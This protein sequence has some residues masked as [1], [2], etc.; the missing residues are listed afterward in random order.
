MAH[1][2][3]TDNNIILIAGVFDVLS[4]K[5][6][7]RA[8]FHA[9]VVTGF[10]VSA[11]YLGEPDFGLLTQSE[12]LDTARRICNAVNIGV[13]IDGDTGFGG[14]LNVQRMIKECI[15]IGVIGILL[16]DQTWPKRCG[17]MKGKSVVTMEEHIQK[18][19]AAVDA[20]ENAQFI[21][22]ARTDAREPIGLDEAIR[23]GKAYKEAGADVIFIEAPKT[24]EELK[25]I[26][27]EVPGLLTVN[28]IE[29]GATP[30]LS[31]ER[32]HEMGFTSVGYVLSGLFA[33]AR[34]LD[35]TYRHLIENGSTNGIRDEMMDFEEF[36]D[37]IGVKT[38]YSLD[39]KYKWD[40]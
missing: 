28:C 23:R 7:E 34:A 21:I 1:K 14:A 13:I 6:A 19:K 2:L 8:G 22:T 25:K 27:S 4:A 9:V 10:G 15:Q 31:L 20:R 16:E 32:Y 33:S 24:I 38:K 30:I 35:R 40:K 18:I 39:E 11:S 5:I 29:G 26:R 36:T 12:I 3:I 37:L 17:H